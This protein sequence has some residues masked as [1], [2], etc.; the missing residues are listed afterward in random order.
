M[1]VVHNLKVKRFR[2]A[3]GFRGSSLWFSLAPRQKYS[4][5]CDKVKLLSLWQQGSRTRE[6]NW[7]GWARDT[8]SDW[9]HHSMAHPDIPRSV[10]Y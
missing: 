3:H 8:C 7:R 10:L 6:Q 5:K 2:V 4:G 9:G 1:S